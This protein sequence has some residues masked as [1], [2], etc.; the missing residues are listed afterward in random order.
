MTGAAGF[1]GSHLCDELIRQGYDVDGLDDL[2]TGNAGNLSQLRG[3]HY[4]RPV[5]GSV[6]DRDLVDQ[7]ARRADVVYHLAAALGTFTIRDHWRH[8][9]TVNLD[10][11][12]NV[13]EAAARQGIPLL[14]TSSSEIYGST[15]GTLHE[16]SPRMLGSPLRPRWAYAEAKA[17]DESLITAYARDDG[18]R[19]VITRLFNVTGPRQ[20]A[21][22]GMV[23]PRFVRQALAGDNLTVHGSGDQR[24]SFCHVADVVPAL[25]ALPG[26]PAAY[27]RAV[28]LG[29]TEQVSIR[30]LALRVLR[31]AGRDGKVLYHPLAA[32][33]GEDWDD[34]QR[35][36]PD[37]T[38]ARELADF[39]VTRDIDDILRDVIASQGGDCA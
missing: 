12:R 2:S 31:L 26:I 36:V 8:S 37:C 3:N 32:V 27:G 20:S 7:L 17:A 34:M 19:A 16:D 25:A 28:N 9:L 4:F 22:F 38:A 1:I 29:A 35:G 11:T 18:L 5:E 15:T 24:R 6:L 33:M 39:T 21:E 23:I 30:E 14:F 10:G 13:T